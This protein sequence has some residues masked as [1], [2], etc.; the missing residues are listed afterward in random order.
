MWISAHRM[1]G[2]IFRISH[3]GI[4][5]VT[6]WILIAVETIHKEDIDTPERGSGLE[7]WGRTR[8]QKT[9]ESWLLQGYSQSTTFSQV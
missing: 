5:D 1:S 2:R 7:G 9:P 3:P 8:R 6:I 4:M